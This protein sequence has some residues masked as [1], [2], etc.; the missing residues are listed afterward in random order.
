MCIF[1]V[2]LSVAL[3]SNE[4]L[5]ISGDGKVQK[6]VLQEGTGTVTPTLNQKVEIRY[7]GWLND[8][9]LFDSTNTKGGT[10]TFVVGRGVIQAWSIA[11][12]TMKVG[13]KAKITVAYQYGFGE[14]GYPPIIPARSDLTFEIE[15]VSII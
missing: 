4:A 1:A 8:G 10:F 14:R 2:L 11:V 13:E 7:S 6:I 5:D 12:Q 9:K 3:S 15:L